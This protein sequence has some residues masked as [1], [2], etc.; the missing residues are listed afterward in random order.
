[1]KNLFKFLLFVLFLT[2][3]VAALYRGSGISFAQQTPSPGLA[4]KA[5]LATGPRINLDEVDVLAAINEQRTRLIARV[6]PSVVAITASSSVSASPTDDEFLYWFFGRSMPGEYRNRQ[7][8]SGFVVSEEG[9]ILTN[10]HV[11]AN[12]Q[13][14]E[15]Q[16]STGET[17]P[18]R[19]IGVDSRLDVAVLKIEFT[20][21]EPLPLGNS[22]LVEAGQTVFAIGNPLGLAE[23]VTDGIISAKARRMSDDSRLE[24]LQTNAVINQGNSGGPLINVRG[25]VVG[26]NTQ[27]LA[28][29]AGSWQGYG[30]AIPANLARQSLEQILERGSVL[31][32]YLGVQMRDVMPANDQQFGITAT[33][34]ALVIQI[35]PNSPAQQA[36][37]QQGDVITSLNE[38][39]IR[40]SSDL[41]NEISDLTPGTRVQLTLER[42]GQ[43]QTLDAVIGEFPADSRAQLSP[44]QPAPRFAQTPRTPGPASPPQIE[45]RNLEQILGLQISSLPSASQGGQSVAGVVVVAVDPASPAAEAIQP[46]DIIE[47]VGTERVTSPKH[48]IS[49][50]RALESARRIE[51]GLRRDNREMKILISMTS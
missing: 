6:M 1:M 48:F 24:F 16:L 8:G 40:S 20:G 28:N 42:A 9:H 43:S 2:F 11:V 31:R 34:G 19:V 3:G 35:V 39:T 49:A 12:A 17:V 22:D 4:E 23:T 18:A 51:L 44:A 33:E 25:E 45:P 26:I 14:I 5:T 7:L 27:I 41:V 21:L 50:L 38:T 37:L 13:N 47:R 30:F 36:G 46:G 32:G 29:R 10:H 15:V